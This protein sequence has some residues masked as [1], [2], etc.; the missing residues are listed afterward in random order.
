MREDISSISLGFEPNDGCGQAGEHDSRTARG[1]AGKAVSQAGGPVRS[2]R[3]TLLKRAAINDIEPLTGTPYADGIQRH[4]QDES[5]FHMHTLQNCM[6]WG[7]GS[8]DGW[9]G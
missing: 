8:M 9:T 2:L 5:D 4:A 6:W 7:G 3:S 1:V